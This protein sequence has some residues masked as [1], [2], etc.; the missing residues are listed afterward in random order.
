MS[1]CV[2]DEKVKPPRY[3]LSTKLVNLWE[4][5]HPMSHPCLPQASWKTRADTVEMRSIGKR[6]GCTMREG[7]ATSVVMLPAVTKR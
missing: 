6:S 4:T 2:V 3:R 1:I 5:A 7:C